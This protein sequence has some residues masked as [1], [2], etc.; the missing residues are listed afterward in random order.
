M[1]NIKAYVDFI[2]F[3]K[4]EA[5]LIPSNSVGLM[6]RGQITKI[7]EDGGPAI[8]KSVKEVTSS[9]KWEVGECF[10]SEVGR[11]KR[12]GLKALYHLVIKRFPNDFTSTSIVIE[13]LD[14]AI[15]KIINDGWKSLTVCGLGI[16]PG[17][18]DISIMAKEIFFVCDKYSSRIAIK[19][20]DSNEEFIKE[21]NKFLGN[22]N[23]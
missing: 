5:L 21:I 16:E 10:V 14:K 13:A 4:S 12:R 17:D 18:L 19:I 2:S 7:I 23:E 6:S 3:P 22:E 1:S 20:I 8:T 9:K 15:K 11:L